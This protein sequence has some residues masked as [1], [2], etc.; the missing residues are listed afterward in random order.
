MKL[1]S[2]FAQNIVLPLADIILKSKINELLIFWRKVQWYDDAT[3]KMLQKQKLR[4]LLFHAKSNISYYKKSMEKID[5]ALEADPYKILKKMPILTKK[6]IKQN[7]PSEIIDNNKNIYRV[8]KTSGSTGEQGVFYHDNFSYSNAIAIQT[9]WWEWSSYKIGD[10]MILFGINPLRGFIKRVKDILFRTTYIDAFDLSKSNI[11]DQ[12]K[13]IKQDQPFIMGY[14]SAI[15][16]IAKF[17]KENDINNIKVKAVVSLGDKVFNHYREIIEDTFNTTLYDTYGACEGTMIAAECDKHVYHIM[18]PH[19]FVEVLDNEGNEVKPGQLG[20]LHVTHLDNFL[21]PLIRYKIGDLGILAD[22]GSL[23]ECGRNLPIMKKLI[24]RDTD[25]I[26]TKSGK[27]LI[28]HF[29]TGIFEH[30]EAIKQFQ[31]IQN[32]NEPFI[33]NYIPSSQ[34][35]REVLKEI[36]LMIDKRANEKVEFEFNIVDKISDSPSGKPQI[37]VRY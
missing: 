24:G 27:P 5:L 30:F 3:L 22:E 2:L 11:K 13:K 34:F 32:K 35:N 1:F 26:Y 19:V 6:I 8:D 9:L 16:H 10:R 17:A 37:I 7:L 29:F 33:I 21:M 14:P 4:K 12:L 18:S 23:C 25:L 20:H 15:Y 31:I 28:V 36:R